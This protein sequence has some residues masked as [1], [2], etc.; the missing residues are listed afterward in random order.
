MKIGR[1]HLLAAAAAV[2][3]AGVVG[4]G[5]TL[6]AWWDQPARAPLLHLSSAE[7]ALFDALA[8][9]IFPE[10]GTPP[11]SGGDANLSRYLDAVLAGMAPTQRSLFRV[12]M[13]G[14]DALARVQAGGFLAELPSEEV[15]AVLRGW[16]TAGDPNLRGVAQSLHIF[17]CMAYLAHPEVQGV[18]APQF[19]C[20]FGGQRGGFGYL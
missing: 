12:A 18:I 10:G 3:G 19:K 9:A 13:H 1:R 5:G 7:I 11:L 2:A 15:A 4:V 16:M 8:D 17:V 6:V 14:L 20:G